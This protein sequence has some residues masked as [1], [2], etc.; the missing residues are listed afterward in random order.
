[1]K[2]LAA[3]LL[4]AVLAACAEKPAPVPPPPTP[5][6]APTPTPTP[7]PEPPPPP[8]ACNATE[9]R[10]LRLAARRAV[11][12]RIVG[13][14]EAS[15]GAYPWMVAIGYSTG[16]GIFNYCGGTLVDPTHVLTA[17]HCQVIPGDVVTVG[18]HNLVDDEGGVQVMVKRAISH[19]AYNPSSH[20][21]D[22]SLVELAKPVLTKYATLGAAPQSGTIRALGWG[23]T[24]E[25]GPTSPV[26][27]EVDVPIVTNAQCAAT[28]GDIIDSQMCA[29][30]AGRDSCQGD[31]G[32]PVLY[33]GKQAGVTSYGYG[34]AR[35][36]LPGVYTRVSAFSDWIEACTP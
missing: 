6:P 21:N 9:N 5:E 23:R 26:L 10:A 15:P 1:M 27:M 17:A 12:P 22:I 7:T 13:G 28:Y 3:V 33:E 30:A 18:R 19:G 4:C 20:H 29:G 31:S 14:Q 8:T 11:S 24:S 32:G 34:C 25:G 2:R 16:S 35:E 36:G